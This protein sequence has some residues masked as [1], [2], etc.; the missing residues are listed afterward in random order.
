M[1]ILITGDLVVRGDYN[2][3]EQIDQ[4]VIDLFSESDY[5]IVNLEAPLTE[6]NY[7]IPKT[8]PHIKGSKKSTQDI[9]KTLQINIATLANNHLKDFGEQGALDTIDFCR[10]QGIQTVGAGKNREDASKILY[11]NGDNSRV[12]IINIAENEWATASENEAGANGMHLIS[13]IRKIRE[14]KTNAAVVIIIVHG[15]HEHY[16]LPSPGMR[17]L[18]RF[19]AEEGA[20]LVIGHHTHCISGN[21]V[22]KGTPIYYSLGNFLFPSNINNSEWFKGLILEIEIEE[23]KIK[24]N[25]HTALVD[26]ESFEI[27]LANEPQQREVNNQ[28]AEY[29]SI[30]TDDIMLNKAWMNFISQSRNLYLYYWSPLSFMKSGNLKSMLNKLKL[31][32]LNK[33]GLLLYQNLIRC[34]SHRELS[35]ET[36]KYYL[37]KK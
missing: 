17:E 6:S 32:F 12:A 26:K 7:K 2:A 10:K 14:A 1:K 37:N 3:S 22:Y 30:I 8:G 25:I 19:Y 13:D 16:S 28:I 33:N 11:L 9:L 34:E 35:D 4:K 27:S 36:F 15:G 24:T 29:S 5:R 23:N 21:E 31:N 20:D 18:Y